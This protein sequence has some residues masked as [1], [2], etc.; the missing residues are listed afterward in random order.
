MSIRIKASM[1]SFALVLIMIMVLPVYAG[2][3][4]EFHDVKAHWAEPCIAKWLE[5]GLV[6][7]YNQ[8]E[9][10]PDDGITRAEFITLVNRVRKRQSC[11]IEFSG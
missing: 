6:K 9:F 3:T 1:I 2:E 10:G 7:G 4:N 5:K 8:S 11:C